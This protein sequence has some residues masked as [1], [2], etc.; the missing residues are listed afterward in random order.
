MDVDILIKYKLIYASLVHCRSQMSINAGY[1][2][3]SRY[4]PIRLNVIDNQNN[5]L[6]E[7]EYKATNDS[8]STSWSGLLRNLIDGKHVK[9]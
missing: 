8:Y 4:Y 5:G 6:K 9:H 1:F 3:A 7:I 2:N